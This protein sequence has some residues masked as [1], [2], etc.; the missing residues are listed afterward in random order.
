VLD[1]PAAESFISRGFG[2]YLGVAIEHFKPSDPPPSGVIYYPSGRTPC[3]YD[4]RK[5]IPLSDNVKRYS[6]VYHLR[7]GKYMDIMFPG[8]TSYKNELGGTA[9]V[10]TGNSRFKYDLTTAFG[11]LNESRKKQLVQIL[12]ELDALPVYYPEDAEVLLKAAKMKDGKLLCAL[13]NIGLDPIEELPLV[14][15]REVKSIRCLDCDGKYR[16]V[17]FSRNGENY[18]LSLTANVFDPLILIIE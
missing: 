16:D 1:G 9:V 14:I 5:I 15:R 8:V 12:T 10:F 6:D 18:T 7:D 3:Q 13:L 4:I 2:R 17:S 11:F